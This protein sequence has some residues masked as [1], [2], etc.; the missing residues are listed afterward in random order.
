MRKGYGS[1]WGESLVEYIVGVGPKKANAIIRQ[2]EIEGYV[3]PS[4]SSRSALYENTIK[5]N[6]LAMASAAPPVKR[7]RARQKL[8]DFIERVEKVN[9]D[10][11]FLYKIDTV[12]LFGSYLANS[13]T[14]N[15]IDLAIKLVP[16]TGDPDKFRQLSQQRIREALN[17]GRRFGNI[18]E[19]IAWPQTEVKR[20][21]KARS[22]I[23]SLHDLDDGVLKGAE[24]RIIYSTE[25]KSEQGSIE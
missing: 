15:D 2:L 25:H 4:E 17:D 19:E 12:V 11:Q 13:E 10:D 9:E 18:V 1:L 16:K 7:E 21:L 20:Y 8:A 3:E 24:S 22:R 5:G 14:V 23:L 6:A